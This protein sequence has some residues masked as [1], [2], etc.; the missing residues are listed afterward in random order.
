M[1]R[2][3]KIEGQ[4]AIKGWHFGNDHQETQDERIADLLAD[5]KAETGRRWMAS[6]NVQSTIEKIL[7]EIKIV[8]HQHNGRV[9]RFS[10]YVPKELLAFLRNADDSDSLFAEWCKI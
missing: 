1:E 9:Q 4:Q 2:R 6:E 8:F 5:C 3:T 7:N 10:V